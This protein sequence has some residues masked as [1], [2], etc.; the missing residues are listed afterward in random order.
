MTQPATRACPAST[1]A[2]FFILCFI[3]GN[4]HPTIQHSFK[5]DL[6]PRN[7]FSD[8]QRDRGNGSRQQAL[9]IEFPDVELRLGPPPDGVHIRRSEDQARAY[10]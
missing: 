7:A 4:C 2:L 8:Q 9:R 10:Q 1:A 5:D 3:G 6:R